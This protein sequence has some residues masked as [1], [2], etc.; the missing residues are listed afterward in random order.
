LCF[1]FSILSKGSTSESIEVS[2]GTDLFTS[3][4]IFFVSTTISSIFL[5]SL[6]SVPSIFSFSLFS[7]VIIS[8]ILVSILLG[9]GFSSSTLFSVTLF[10]FSVTDCNLRSSIVLLLFNSSIEGCFKRII[11]FCL[12]SCFS[13]SIGTVSGVSDC[14]KVVLM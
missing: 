6:G 7:V 1:N 13:G 10:I 8:E 9:S 2:I 5:F 14:F 4:S 12:I 11:I 3:F